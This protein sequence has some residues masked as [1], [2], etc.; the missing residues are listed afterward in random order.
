MMVSCG[1]MVLSRFLKSMNKMSK[2]IH[3]RASIGGVVFGEGLLLNS[4]GYSFE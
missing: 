3:F 2:L 4:R 1:N